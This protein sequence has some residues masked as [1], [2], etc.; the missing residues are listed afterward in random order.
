MGLILALTVAGWIPRPWLHLDLA[1]VALLGLL[2]A[3]AVGSF[4][5]PALQALDWGML[6]FFG[7]V[8]GLGRLA[9]ALGLDAEAGALIQRPWATAGPGRSAWCWPSRW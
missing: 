1:S 7:A 5:T 6:L 8:L 4:D 9:A 3:A 2:G